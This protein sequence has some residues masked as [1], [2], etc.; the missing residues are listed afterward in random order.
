[1][2][3]FV[4]FLSVVLCTLL[5]L[6]VFSG[7]SCA[8]TPE[9]IS[10]LSGNYE[11][12]KFLELQVISENS[13]NLTFS[14]SINFDK[15][16][17]TE[18]QTNQM[19]NVI[20]QDLGNGKWQITS[21]ESFDCTKSY[22]IE[23]Y[24]LDERKNSLYFKDSFIGHNAR[25]PQVVINE[26]RT[27]YSKPKVEFI[28]LKV[29]SDGNLGGM[30]LV[31]ASDEDSYILPS[32]EVKSGDLVVIHYRNIEE[33]C[34]NELT[35]DLSLSSA[36]E[37]SE[38]RDFWI[39]NEK[40]RISK[41]DVIL[42]KNKFQGDIVDSVLFSESSFTNWKTDFMSECATLAISS[43]NWFGE[44]A[45]S[46]GLTATRTLSRQNLNKDN[47]AWIVVA[48]SKATPGKENSTQRYVAK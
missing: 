14:T 19:I 20:H 44:N 10:I 5:F 28:E 23:G 47:S 3:I 18:S 25:V 4:N 22:I 13:I 2:K 27:E 37:S 39:E 33:G 30:E 1:M 15:I 35:D 46:D 16:Q 21:E 45:N 48:T 6:I 26:I 29:L 41:S 42:L 7:I 24:V 11:S 17:I 8:I 31:I 38:S 34:I 36:T 9:G 43:G 32:V 40:A 12:P